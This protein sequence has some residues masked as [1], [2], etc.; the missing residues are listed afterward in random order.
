[1]INNKK[2]T[3]RIK[4]K[5]N[6]NA[7]SQKKEPRM[8]S[9]TRTWI[10]IDKAA[11]IHNLRFLQQT[12]QDTEIAAV[13][14]GNAYGHG[15]EQIVPIAQNNGIN[16]F[17]VFS[18]DEACR[19][20]SV[21][22]KT[23]KLIIMGY[24]PNDSY[25]W[26]IK[27]EIEFFVYETGDLADAIKAAKLQKKPALVHLELETGMN[28]T[29]LDDH[30]LKKALKLI[31]E[32]KKDV[33]IAGVCTHFAG[34]ESIA[35][36]VR[37][38]RQ[39][40]NYNRQLLQVKK[41][42]YTPDKLHMAC[43]AAAI[44]YPRTRKDLIRVGILQYGFWPSF[45]TRIAYMQKYKHTIDP[46][47]RVLSWKS[48]VMHVKTVEPGEFI[49]YGTAFFASE[50]KKIAVVPVGYADGFNRS[51]SNNGRVLIHGKIAQVIGTINMNMLIADI[52]SIKNVKPG[53]EVVLIGKQKNNTINVSSFSE[54]TQQV[55]YEL[56]TRLPDSIPRII[57]G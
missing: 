54:F 30:N 13:V 17:T 14:K 45:E 33:H 16:Y 12:F 6:G 18:L 8:P 29:G 19:A 46:L 26:V 22:N 48:R 39:I 1:M 20:F 24:I 21:M 25:D 44:S 47:R 56:L 51:L 37:I 43:S 38:K 23:A 42:G 10:E 55:N 50:K 52:T 5:Q 15:I 9:Y 41:S 35:N 7:A 31:N 27:N 11:Y 53:D 36:H 3:S 49:S 57:K 34:A 32:N 4:K 40:I 2:I 28:R